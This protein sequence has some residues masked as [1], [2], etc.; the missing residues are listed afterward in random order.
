MALDNSSNGSYMGNTRA[1]SSSGFINRSTDFHGK[2]NANLIKET[3]Y[4]DD[5]LNKMLTAKYNGHKNLLTPQS[6]DV[7][8]G[9]SMTYT[10][11]DAIG[12]GH[13]LL[14]GVT[15]PGGEYSASTISGTLRQYGKVMYVTDIART[16]LRYDI[17]EAIRKQMASSASRT[18]DSICRDEIHAQAGVR[19]YPTIMNYVKGK[20]MTPTRAANKISEITAEHGF[21]FW[22]VFNGKTN[23]QADETIGLT[24]RVRCSLSVHG[25]ESLLKDPWFVDNLAGNGMLEKWDNGKINSFSGIDFEVI[26]NTKSY[27]PGQYVKEAPGNREDNTVAQGVILETAILSIPGYGIRLDLVSAARRAG[28]GGVQ[29]LESADEPTKDDP[30]RQRTSIGYKFLFGVLLPLPQAYQIYYFAREG[31]A[32]NAMKLNINQLS[33][34]DYSTFIGYTESPNATQIITDFKN[35]VER[36]IRSEFKTILPSDYKLGDVMVEAAYGGTQQKFTDT[37]LQNSTSGDW[38][39]LSMTITGTGANLTGKITVVSQLQILDKN[40]PLAGQ[41]IYDLIKVVELGELEN[42][43]SKT[44]I[45]AVKDKNPAVTYNNLSVSG[46]PDVTQGQAVIISNDFQGGQFVYFRVKSAPSTPSSSGEK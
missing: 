8:S 37:V 5:I 15:P 17:F 27:G 42:G 9:L 40:I 43:E 18:I 38:G 41:K 11:E 12:E 31:G 10:R 22:D 35:R 26:P 45:Q 39:R 20:R 4:A 1:N 44:I 3:N 6:I 25:A 16:I 24:S 33:L 7:H 14:D 28:G 30:L 46:V 32:G 23:L 2:N 36:Q 29:Y 21:N 19:I 34:I 13:L